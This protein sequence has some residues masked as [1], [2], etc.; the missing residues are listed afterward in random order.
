VEAVAAALAQRFSITLAVEA[1]DE[2]ALGAGTSAN[3]MACI[4]LQ[5]NG[6]TCS[7]AALAEDTTSATLQALLNAV[8][9]VVPGVHASAKAA[10]EALSV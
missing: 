8:A 10:D 7:A 6:Q 4:R 1:Y 5:A 3:A 2:F 9:Q